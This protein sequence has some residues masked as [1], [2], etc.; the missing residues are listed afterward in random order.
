MEPMLVVCKVYL[1]A[2]DPPGSVKDSRGAYKEAQRLQAWGCFQQNLAVSLAMDVWHSLF[3]LVHFYSLCIVLYSVRK[4][5]F[6][7]QRLGDAQKP[8]K[9]YN[10]LETDHH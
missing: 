7:D 6:N 8:N 4:D 3:V 9:I 1:S 5:S 10:L 2:C